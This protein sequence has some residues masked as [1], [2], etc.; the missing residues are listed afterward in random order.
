MSQL[1]VCLA[2][3]RELIGINY[4]GKCNVSS[5]S[6]VIVRRAVALVEKLQLALV[7]GD[8]SKLVEDRGGTTNVAPDR[9]T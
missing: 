1:R 9:A 4:R 8:V 5:G 7:L 2:L 6:D 3:P